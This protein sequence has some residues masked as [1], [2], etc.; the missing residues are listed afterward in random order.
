MNI[1]ELIDFLYREWF[2]DTFLSFHNIHL[3]IAPL[4][5][6]QLRTPQAIKKPNHLKPEETDVLFPCSVA[7]CRNRYLQI[8]GTQLVLKKCSWFWTWSHDLYRCFPGRQ[9][10]VSLLVTWP[11]AVMLALQLN[12]SYLKEH[13]ISG[14][15]CL[16]ETDLSLG[17]FGF[18][19]CMCVGLL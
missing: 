2:I 9:E 6:F 11:Q 12:C 3:L 16:T 4:I 5:W 15:E 19:F 1:E 18:I 13:L 14:T 7:V 8:I 17:L 10:H